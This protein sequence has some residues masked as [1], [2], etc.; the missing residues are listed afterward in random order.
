MNPKADKL[1]I[2]LIED[3]GEIADSLKE[4]TERE[5]HVQVTNAPHK[6]AALKE[7]KTA[8]R[9]F[10][11][12]IVDMMLPENQS[13]LDDLV[14]LD[15]QRAEALME[16]ADRTG[17]DTDYLDKHIAALRRR[18]DELDREIDARLAL[19]G[20]C[21]I[22]EWYSDHLNPGQSPDSRRPLDV[23]VI[24]FTARGLA[25]IRSRCEKIVER[26]RLKWLEKPVDEKDIVHALQQLLGL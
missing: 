23:P 11:A 16:L 17:L 8:G 19:E 6:A 9:R 1:Q 12:L 3:N 7:L 5:L 21:E 10:A 25:E 20:G 26:S 18:I 24:I 15:P 22:L 13:D 14:R 4:Y 2:L